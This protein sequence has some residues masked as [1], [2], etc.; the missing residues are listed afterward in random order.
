MPIVLVYSIYMYI[1]I[2]YVYVTVYI[3]ISSG[4]FSYTFV[5]FYVICL[6]SCVTPW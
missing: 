5:Q 4:G 3:Y 1:Y 2:V 6:W